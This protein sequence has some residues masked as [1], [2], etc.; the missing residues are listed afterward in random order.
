MDFFLYIALFLRIIWSINF[1]KHILK[2]SQKKSLWML[3]LTWIMCI[4]SFYLEI[5]PFYLVDGL[6]LIMSF[7]YVYK[8]Y[9]KKFNSKKC[10]IEMPFL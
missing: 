3:F 2:K 6:W 5:S 9:N 7:Y 8:D 10:Q 4:I 1:M